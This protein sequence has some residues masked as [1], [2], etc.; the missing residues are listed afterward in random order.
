MEKL[1]ISPIQLITQIINFVIMVVVLKKLLYQPILTALENR[2]KKIEEG[3]HSSEKIKEELEKVGKKK[4]DI[5]QKAQ[6][7]AR[8][9][10]ENGKKT[11]EGVKD[12]ILKNA[13][14]EAVAIIEKGRKDLDQQ[15]KEMESRLERE[16]VEI[17]AEMAVKALGDV[18]TTADQKMII[19]KKL[20]KVFQS[21]K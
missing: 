12:E 14:I 13:Q 15:R 4:A 16:T 10:V 3:L 5:L 17:A 11:A 1:G 7:E 2:R 21:V 6:I 20:K 9:I 18:L 8:G 19:D